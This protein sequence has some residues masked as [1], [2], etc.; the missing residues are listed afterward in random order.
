MYRA[1]VVPS[2]F[3]ES[4]TQCST[5]FN[6]AGELKLPKRFLVPPP[7][8]DHPT[9]EFLVKSG[10]SLY[11]SAES[12]KI[13]HVSLLTSLTCGLKADSRIEQPVHF[14]TLSPSQ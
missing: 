14:A 4:L 12:Q 2:S 7:H 11:A 8:I 1:V 5:F 10:V 6:Y 9:G 3:S 13:G